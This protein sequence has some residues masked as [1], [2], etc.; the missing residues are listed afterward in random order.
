MECKQRNIAEML[1]D[2]FTGDLSME[3]HMQV[4]RHLDECE[5]CRTNL[6]TMTL[7]AGGIAQDSDDVNQNHV[8]PR[9]ISAYYREKASLSESTLSKIEAHLE[10]CE[11]CSYDLQLLRDMETELFRSVEV[12]KDTRTVG[13][14]LATFV[15]SL[16]RKPALAYFILAL[17]IYPA[18]MYVLEER[19]A[20][21]DSAGYVELRSSLRSNEE[22]P[23]VERASQTEILRISLPQYHN[24]DVFDYTFSIRA[25]DSDL[26]LRA[27]IVPD[28]SAQGE[29]DLLIGGRYL[30]DGVY[31]LIVNER[32]LDD[33]SSVSVEMFAFELTTSTLE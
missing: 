17:T 25:L 32:E 13:Q 15:W 28:F 26:D 2:Y 30:A 6:Q 11:S 20:S 4:E 19:Q 7:L 8:H 16:V 1:T 10:A 31:Y 24:L 14:K 12:A 21:I 27:D 9:L 18:S 23:L 5:G 22:L 3:Q 29:I 33:T